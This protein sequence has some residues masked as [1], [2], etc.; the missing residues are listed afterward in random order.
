VPGT[1]PEDE[2]SE[3][4][5][6]IALCSDAMSEGINLQRAA[7]VVLLDTP[8]VIRIAEQRVGRIDRMNSPHESITVWWPD[9]SPPFQSQKRDLLIERHSVNGRL[10]GNNIKLPERLNGR[11]EESLFA[12][13]ETSPIATDQMIDEYEKRQNAGPE[14]RLEDA[15]QPVRR[16]VGL[17]ESTAPPLPLIERSVY[18]PFAQ[19]TAAVWSRITVREASAR[20]GFFCL[21][22]QERRAPRW[23]LLRR[24]VPDAASSLKLDAFAWSVE[25]RLSRIADTLPA[26]IQDTRDVEGQETPQFWDAIEPE[27][28]EMTGELQN[29]ERELLSNRARHALWLLREAV[30]R[31]ELD[32]KAGSERERVCTFL[33]DVTSGN[34]DPSVNLHD[35][36]DAWLGVV[37]PRYVAWKRERTRSYGR[38]PVRLK[39][40]KPHLVRHP[41]ETEALRRVAEA[42]R[43]EQPIRRRIVAA[44]VAFP[45]ERNPV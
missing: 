35:L 7:S 20:W 15:F 16:L 21:R 39:D 44:I 42:A 2:T 1:G 23:V 33:K 19:E 4:K 30:Y 40:M 10:M 27:L 11:G 17:E 43:P 34:Q 31:Y 18:E 45:V 14:E 3:E 8:S 26:L 5:G 38:D 6:L 28:T 36:T 24:G 9:D 41:I 29:Q 12:D 13:D 32:A 37:Q 25:T 22:G